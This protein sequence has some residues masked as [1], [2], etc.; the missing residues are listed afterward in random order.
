MEEVLSWLDTKHVD[1]NVFILVIASGFFQQR[2]L[3]PFCWY[4]KDPRYDATIKTL[5]VSAV[6]CALYI[7][8]YK[9]QMREVPAAERNPGEAAMKFFISYACATSFYEVIVRLFKRFFTKKTGID[10]DDV[11]TDTT[12]P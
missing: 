6:F 3:T 1:F 9:I 7:W 11:K 2:F 5:A 10:I 4:K 12:K 8:I